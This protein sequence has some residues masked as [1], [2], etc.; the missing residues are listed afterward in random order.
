MEKLKL[1]NNKKSCSM[2]LINDGNLYLNYFSNEDNI[3]IDKIQKTEQTTSIKKNDYLILK[4]LSYIGRVVLTIYSF[5]AMIYLFTLIFQYFIILGGIIYIIDNKFG[6]VIFGIFYI[7]FS[8]LASNVLII[9]LFEFFTF[10]FYKC[11]NFLSHLFILI[12]FIFDTKLL[13]GKDEN[14][15]YKINM[16]Y[17]IIL[18]V[19]GIIFVVAYLLTLTKGI[20]GF[21]D[22]VVFISLIL[23]FVYFVI[24]Y[25]GYYIYS[26]YLF[27]KIIKNGKQEQNKNIIN[28][29][30]TS[31]LLTLYDAIDSGIYLS[32]RDKEF[33]KYNIFSYIF[34]PLLAKNYIGYKCRNKVRNWEHYE[35]YWSIIL[36]IIF[37]IL[38]II[39]LIFY[40]GFILNSS[41][42]SDLLIILF[43]ILIFPISIF[44]TFPFCCK[45][46]RY[47]NSCFSN[48]KIYK[49]EYNSI[50]VPIVRIVSHVLL[51]FFSVILILCFYID[52]DS[53]KER[54]ILQTLNPV[55]RTDKSNTL[56]Y[57]TCNA[58]INN[59]P[60]LQYFPMMQ[61]SYFY[62]NNT[63][64]LEKDQP[65][66]KLFY[67]DKEYELTVIGDLIERK[68]DITLKM[69]HYDIKI[70][71]DN[72]EMT[73]LSIKGTTT[74]N[75]IFIDIQLF[76][77]SVFLTV[78]TKFSLLRY[79]KNSL[80]Y[81]M[82]RRILTAPLDMFYEYT[83]VYDSIN[84][85][86][87]AYKAN[88]KNFK[89][90]TIF[91]GQ[92]LG[93][94]LAKLMGKLFNKKAISLSG[95]G[96][97]A[98]SSLW[99][100]QGN[101]ENFEYSAIE[102]VPDMDL[103]PRVEISA[104]SI[105]N[106]ICDAGIFGCHN[107]KLSFCNALIMCRDEAYYEYCKKISEYSDKK[108][109]HFLKITEI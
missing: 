83:V 41:V 85:L 95:P 87:R 54:E 62:Y 34:N 31:F 17:D 75:E 24:L 59:I 30:K 10:P 46:H 1:K 103:V 81:K 8:I 52:S 39:V 76:C 104:G 98:F 89:S 29:D 79:K 12:D 37:Y 73:V 15:V 94:G 61:D 44:F 42:K 88:F 48:E 91:V 6:E 71:K 11:R 90:N 40:F 72:T 102:I 14:S 55:K 64:F 105:Y 27:F 93:G 32:V 74:S 68:R 109:K 25:M 86:I 20:F 2:E 108:I 78:L 49:I 23:V 36:K 70:L 35:F 99:D 38:F 47:T 9:P 77:P 66:R 101:T 51:V 69:I 65:F 53:E 106:I 18:T 56:I 80:S 100:F 96:I 97:N 19:Y 107:M 63:S 7:I 92:S 82:S 5:Y 45:N 50:L 4:G 26:I 57:N 28:Q 33:H 22:I 60:L 16:V 43:L 58:K 13:N 84:E 67:D 21:L 3:K